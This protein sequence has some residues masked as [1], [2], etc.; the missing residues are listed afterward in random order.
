MTVR[1][2]L[3]TTLMSLRATPRSP[4]PDFSTAVEM[5]VRSAIEPMNTLHS[6]GK[7]YVIVLEGIL[8]VVMRIKR[9]FYGPFGI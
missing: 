2:S 1:V 3:G 5:T 4:L 9:K 7:G 8:E 6:T